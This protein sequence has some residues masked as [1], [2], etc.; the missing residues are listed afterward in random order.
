MEILLGS[1]K[2]EY[3]K[4]GNKIVQGFY[5][6]IQFVNLF[7]NREKE[8]NVQNI[9]SILSELSQEILKI[10]GAT[11]TIKYYVCKSAAEG[12]MCIA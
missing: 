5:Y 6:F 9:N 12:W 2:K 11:T 1:S 7:K 10:H 4:S 8:I 3:L